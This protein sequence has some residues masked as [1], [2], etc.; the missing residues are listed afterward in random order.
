MEEMQPGR[1]AEPA[2]AGVESAPPPKRH[3]NRLALVAVALVAVILVVALV[4]LSILSSPQIPSYLPLPVGTV[5]SLLPQ[6]GTGGTVVSYA[7]HFNASA[8]GAMSAPAG[9]CLQVLGAWRATAPTTAIGAFPPEYKNGTIHITSIEAQLYAQ[10][11]VTFSSS[12]PDTITVTHA[13]Q[14]VAVACA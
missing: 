9:K 13:I 8:G 1:P 7:R 12:Q 3:A 6:E 5:F 2:Q 4:S 10:W 14:F 11:G